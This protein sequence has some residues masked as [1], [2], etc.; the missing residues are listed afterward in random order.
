M[1]SILKTHRDYIVFV[2]VAIFLPYISLSVAEATDMILYGLFAMAFNIL[3]GFT[4]IL[5]FGHGLF[6]GLGAYGTGLYLRWVEV[7]PISLIVGIFSATLIAAIVAYFCTIR[8]G[9]YFAMIT[10]AFNQLFYFI[11]YSWRSFTG[12]DDGLIGLKRFEINIPFISTIYLTDHFVRYYFFL[13]IVAISIYLIKRIVESPFGLVLQGIRENEERVK[14]IGYD[15]DR[16]KFVSFL[17]SGLFSGIAGALYVIHLKYV[18]ITTLHWSFS[19]EVI[20]MTLL[21]GMY[22]LFGPF[23]GAIL[24]VFLR[25]LFCKYTTNWQLIVGALFI[26]LTLW[27]RRGVLGR[28][29]SYLEV[30]K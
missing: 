6:F 29:V 9:V 5:S 30:H 25:D 2:I 24:Y 28:L 8:K 10:I 27:L 11:F 20:M 23:G 19:G 26:I 1:N 3:L 15:V 16:Y 12:G 22:T 17:L 21:G 13:I 18:G 14:C 7:S 4:G